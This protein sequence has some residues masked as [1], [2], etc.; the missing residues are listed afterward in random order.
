M[1]GLFLLIGMANEEATTIS[2]SSR[3]WF[4][5]GEIFIFVIG[6]WADRKIKKEKTDTDD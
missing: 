1:A 5:V 3:L 2:V 4:L 6:F